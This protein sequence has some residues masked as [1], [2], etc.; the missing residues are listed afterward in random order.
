MKQSVGEGTS[1]L[2]GLAV[3]TWSWDTSR[4][5]PCCSRS[6]PSA[7]RMT[8]SSASICCSCSN[9]T[10]Y[11]SAMLHRVRATSDV[12]KCHPNRAATVPMPPLPPMG[13]R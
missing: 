2:V 5:W 4:L 11:V 6:A 1:S 7:W 3:R 10:P 12:R 8:H 9:G 13:S